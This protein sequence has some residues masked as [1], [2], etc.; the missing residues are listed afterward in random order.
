MLTGPKPNGG[1]FVNGYERPPMAEGVIEMGGP[2]QLQLPAPGTSYKPSPRD[3]T[4]EE[5]T[6]AQAQM[7]GG[8][9]PD[10]AMTPAVIRTP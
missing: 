4:P 3:I 7:R 9:L 6:R 5:V 2:Q 1:G 8:N 10:P